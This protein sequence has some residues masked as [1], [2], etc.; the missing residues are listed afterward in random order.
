MSPATVA[1]QANNGPPTAVVPVRERL[2][3]HD[4]GRNAHLFD[5]ARFEQSQRVAMAMANSNLLPKHLLGVDGDP[6]RSRMQSQANC[7][8]IVNQAIRWGF[9]PFAIMDETYVVHGKLGYQGKLVAAVVNA[10]A[11]LKSRLKYTFAGKKGTDEFEVTVKGHFDGEDEPCEITLSV[12]QAKTDNKM[13]KTDPEQK[14]CYSGATKW[15][16]RYCPEIL[17]GVATDDDLEHINMIDAPAP[18]ATVAELGRQ[19]GAPPKVE[20]EPP[21]TETEPAKVETPAPKQETAE[22]KAE[23]PAEHPSVAASKATKKNHA[24]LLR[25]LNKQI[26]DQKISEGRVMTALVKISAV[27]ESCDEPS[28]G[29]L[30]SLTEHQISAVIDELAKPQS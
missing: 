12:G 22:S 21:K 6:D 13:W 29:I 24:A 19:L 23:T 8:R 15:A 2:V 30:P 14:L 4:E 10:R 5:T 26:E 16:R 9:D 28:K 25:T 7:L 1:P 18:A 11:G 3:S 17:L 27:S 20:T